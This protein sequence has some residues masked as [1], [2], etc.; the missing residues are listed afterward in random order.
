MNQDLRNLELQLSVRP[1]LNYLKS[2]NQKYAFYTI[3]Q[4]HIAYPPTYQSIC[5]FVAKF[6]VDH[7]GS[8]KSI[9]N[10]ISAIKTMCHIIAVPWLSL[11]SQKGL[12]RVV[13]RY[14]YAVGS[15]VFVYIFSSAPSKFISQ[16]SND[17][18]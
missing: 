3:G 6:A 17:L 13:N 1:G 11:D 2:I 12:H 10:I 8:F 14:P 9:A 16:G 18:Y 7:D 15:E 5:S 4:G